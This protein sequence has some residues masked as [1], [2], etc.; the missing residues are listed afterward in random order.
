MKALK[1]ILIAFISIVALVVIAG[2]FLPSQVHIERSLMMKSPPSSVFSQ[3]ND[4][5][6]WNGWMPFNKMD[7]TMKQTY[8]EKTMGEGASYSWESKKM[9]NGSVTI[10]KSMPNENIDVALYFKEMG[11]AKSG[12]KIEKTDG[13]TKVTW[14]MEQEMGNNPINRIKGAIMTKFMGPVFDRGLKDLD[15]TSALVPIPVDSTAM[16]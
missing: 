15:S 9:G 16:H 7:S 4:L 2:F 5:K 14:T 12:Y 3:I 6:T 8:G 13:G 1:V 11:T 10:S